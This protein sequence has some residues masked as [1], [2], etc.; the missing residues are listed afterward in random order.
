MPSGGFTK[1]AKVLQKNAWPGHYLKCSTVSKIGLY[2]LEE[3]FRVF[4]FQM[5]GDTPL[6]T[7]L[8]Y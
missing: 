4:S 8:K 7:L 6:A 1:R 3:L 5:N 2:F